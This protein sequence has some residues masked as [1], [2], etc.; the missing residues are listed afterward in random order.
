MKE[1]FFLDTNVLIYATLQ[2]DQRAGAAQ[3]LLKRGGTI[4]VQV[5]NEFAH[6]ASR[7]FRRPW[8]E[9]ADAIGA[10]RTL[11]T[12]LLPVT[13]TMHETAI[14]LAASTGYQIYDA[15]I[16][17][18]ALEAGCSTLFSE[19]MLDGHVIDGRLRIVNPFQ[20]SGPSHAC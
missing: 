16:V 1:T 12:R 4:S 6:T 15:L 20:L 19:D 18:A 10:M 17:A 9:I 5:L 13:A 2:T 14:R 11:C 3:S 7:R 8:P